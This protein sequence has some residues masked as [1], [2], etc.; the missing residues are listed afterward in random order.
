MKVTY[1]KVTIAYLYPLSIEMLYSVV[2]LDSKARR[3]MMTMASP[4]RMLQRRIAFRANDPQG[5]L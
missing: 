2:S 4:Y 1:L 3:N 5:K